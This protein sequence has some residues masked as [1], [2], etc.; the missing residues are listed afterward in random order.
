MPQV[1]QEYPSDLTDRQWELIKKL[2]PTARSGGRPRT[3][4]IREVINAT[5][6]VIRAGCA[7]RSLPNDF[8]PWSTVYDYFS[9]WKRAG[10]WK[11]IHDLIVAVVRMKAGRK[12]F[13]RTLIIDSQSIRAHYGENRGFDHNWP[14]FHKIPTHKPIF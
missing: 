13:P 9:R 5:F 14:L 11:R 12:P 1:R 4:D 8:P 7:W 2:I 3:T 10:V 6:Y